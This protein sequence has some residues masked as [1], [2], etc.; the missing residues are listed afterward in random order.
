MSRRLGFEPTN[1]AKYRYANGYEGIDFD[2]ECCCDCGAYLQRLNTA[3]TRRSLALGLGMASFVMGIF[4]FIYPTPDLS[5]EQEIVNKISELDEEVK[6]AAAINNQRKEELK[7]I[8]SDFSQ[9]LQLVKQHQ[10]QYED[11]NSLLN[12]KLRSYEARGFLSSNLSGRYDLTVPGLGT[13]LPN[14]LTA[15]ALQPA[16][17]VSKER[18]QVSIVIGIPT[19]KREFQSYLI[20]TLTSV[21]ENMNENEMQ[22]SLVVVFIAETDP[23]NVY[24]VMS[25][26][27]SQFSK[28]ME[29]GALD[30]ISPPS[31]YYPDMTSLRKTLGDDM[32]RVAWRSKQALDFAFLMMYCQSKATFYVQLEDDVL[33]KNGYM[34]I[35]KNTALERISKK[36]NFFVLDFCQ[37]GFIGKMFRSAD[38]PWLVQFFIMF[39]NDQPVDWLLENILRSKVC[40]LDQDAKKCKKEKDKLWIHYKPSLFQHIGTHSSLKGKIQ[41][42]KD[43]QF[44]RVSLYKGHRNPPAEI[45]SPIKHYKH[46]SLERAYRGDTFFWGL[47]PQKGDKI[48]FR[49]KPPVILEMYKLVTGNLEH[50]SD[51]FLNTTCQI[52][53]QDVGIATKFNAK[54][55]NGWIYAGEFNNFGVAEGQLGAKYGPIAAFRL[56]VG[57]SSENWAIL[58]E[59]YFKPS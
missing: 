51:R 46:Y 57:T 27:Q 39:Y 59:I 28:Y 13:F 24:Q 14:T 36:Q 21:F 18:A 44:G 50:P 5:L 55:A 37:L 11:N 4:I 7:E 34:G 16:F 29:D 20:P 8:A 33:T 31:E 40:K 2:D 35:M 25:E 15:R 54:D 19:V 43:R 45:D 42:L 32:E 12:Q 30:V 52:K 23:D 38:L 58:S 22:D 56:N 9:L 41:K 10:D 26:I 49:F 48:V 53:L 1:M 3:R 6:H 47:V 17:K